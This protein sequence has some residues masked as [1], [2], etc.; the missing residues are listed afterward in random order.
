MESLSNAGSGSYSVFEGKNLS[1][2]SGSRS[3]Y[4]ALLSRIISLGSADPISA[5]EGELHF[6]TLQINNADCSNL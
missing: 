1:L 6:F 5:F 3:I 2:I 4:G